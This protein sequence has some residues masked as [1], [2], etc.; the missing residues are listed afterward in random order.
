MK[1]N[2]N[3]LRVEQEEVTI[4]KSFDGQN[5]TYIVIAFNRSPSEILATF[6]TSYHAMQY[7][8]HEGYDYIIEDCLKNC[9]C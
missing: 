4:V 9:S 7:C 5:K 3:Q 2:N 6:K 8:N 1:E